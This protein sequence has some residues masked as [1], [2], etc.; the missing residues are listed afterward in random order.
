MAASLF[1][2]GIES[3]KRQVLFTDTVIYKAVL[4]MPSP[5]L[6]ICLFFVFFGRSS[7]YVSAEA[8][9]VLQTP[10]IH[11][12]STPRSHVT[13]PR[14]TPQSILKVRQISNK[15]P[16]MHGVSPLSIGDKDKGNFG[17]LILYY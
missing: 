14:P 12:K 10:I 7:K 9:S 16:N 11:R 8:L 4:V 15:S 17:S 5:H 3:N 6:Y 1:S 13:S 2:Y